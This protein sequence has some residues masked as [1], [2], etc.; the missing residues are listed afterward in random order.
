MGCL[1]GLMGVTLAQPP[2]RT[3]HRPLAI[4]R[5]N[6]AEPGETYRISPPGLWGVG[7]LQTGP[8][9]GE[10]SWRPQKQQVCPERC[11]AF[12]LTVT[13]PRELDSHPQATHERPPCRRRGAQRLQA[14]CLQRVFVR[15]GYGAAERPLPRGLWLLECDSRDLVSTSRGVFP[16]SPRGCRLEPG[17]MAPYTSRSPGENEPEHDVGERPERG[18]FPQRRTQL[19]LERGVASTS[20]VTPQGSLERWPTPA[21]ARNAREDPGETRM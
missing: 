13:G 7:G 4:G 19:G 3:R 5:V 8:H 9:G 1:L 10:T 12:G 11:R 2:W 17:F 15:S 18:R 20:A 6:S 21:R 14:P 16:R